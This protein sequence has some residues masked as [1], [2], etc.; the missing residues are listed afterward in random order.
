LRAFTLIELLVVV[1]VI[2][3][4]VS[5]LL[6]ALSKAREQAKRVVCGSNLRQVGLTY[7]YYCYDARDR[8]DNSF[9]RLLDDALLAP[10]RHSTVNRCK[11]D[12]KT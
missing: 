7:L 1:S 8:R 11:K 10:V 6:P 3:V 2:A 9:C 12:H 5:I 4:L